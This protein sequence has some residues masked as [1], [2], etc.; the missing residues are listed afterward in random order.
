MYGRSFYFI[1]ND[2]ALA[3]IYM[4]RLC[5][6]KHGLATIS[7]ENNVLNVYDGI[8]DFLLLFY[9]VKKNSFNPILTTE[10]P[11]L[12]VYKFFFFEI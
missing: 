6:H 4:K 7:N 3:I 8:I 1:S 5:K 12:R 2:K 11:K 9:T 10:L